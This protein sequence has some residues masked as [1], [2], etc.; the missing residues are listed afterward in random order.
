MENDKIQTSESQQENTHEKFKKIIKYIQGNVGAF[1]FLTTTTIAVSGVILRVIIYLI[2]YGK[3]KYYNISSSLIDVSG[4]NVLYDLFV[5]GVFILLFILLNLILSF[6]WRSKSKMRIKVGWSLLFVSFPNFILVFCL[7]VDNIHGIKYS[8]LEIGIFLFIG[9]LLG[10]VLFFIGL[11][12]GICEYVFNLKQKNKIKNE[13]TKESKNEK[14]SKAE[15]TTKNEERLN[16]YKLGFIL[17]AILLI[18]SLI[19]FIIVGYI[20]ACT[21]RQFK[22]IYNDDNTCYAVVYENPNR[23][24]ITECE[25]EGDYVSFPHPDTQREIDRDEVKYQWQ[26]L[27]QRR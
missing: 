1:T 26:T 22:I 23:Y 14:S 27:T 17:L 10:M 4:D 5:K 13:G 12:D 9:L 8:M 16:N 3:T 20:A 18:F 15:N 19:L 6:I 21:Q 25:I 24:V 11:Y 7:I 2:E